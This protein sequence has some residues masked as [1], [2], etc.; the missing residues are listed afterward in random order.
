[1]KERTSQ[2]ESDRQWRFTVVATV[3]G[4]FTLLS[5]LWL[6]AWGA[7]APVMGDAEATLMAQPATDKAANETAFEFSYAAPSANRK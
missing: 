6:G 5:G 7:G 3:V 1:M 4:A 2:A